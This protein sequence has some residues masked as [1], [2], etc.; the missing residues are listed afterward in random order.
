MSQHSSGVS[1]AQPHPQLQF[2]T[3]SISHVATFVE[4]GLVRIEPE[5]IGCGR[6]MPLEGLSVSP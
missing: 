1:S 5:P 3:L 2:R 6:L 4:Y